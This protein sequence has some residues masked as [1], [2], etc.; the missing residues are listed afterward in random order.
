MRRSDFLASLMISRLVFMIPE[1]LVLLVTAWLMFGVTI[2]GSVG[3]VVFLILLG[4]FCFAGVGL[5]VASRANTMETVSGLMN[6]VMLPMWVLSGIFFS[7]ERFPE[8]MQPFI[9]VL[10]L[11]ALL[12]ALRAVMLDGA[13]LA[14][15]WVE[16]LTLA[17]WGCVSFAVALRIFRWN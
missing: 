16:M 8:F 6:L 3:A 13:A 1:V 14:T 9:Q 11:T 7:S 4:A 12:N 5:L 17:L 2:A 15:Q 10:P